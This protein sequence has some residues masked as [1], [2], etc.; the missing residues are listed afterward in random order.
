MQEA[1]ACAP[2]TGGG[3]RVMAKALG[4]AGL[5]QYSGRR[6]M[7]GDEGPEWHKLGA[8]PRRWSSR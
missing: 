8:R 5:V 2:W 3:P 4:G 6:H 7:G 1:F